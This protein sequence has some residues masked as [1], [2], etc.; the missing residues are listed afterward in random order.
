M[1]SFEMLPLMDA[2]VQNPYAAKIEEIFAAM[3]M[4]QSGRINLVLADSEIPHGVQAGL[5]ALEIL[6]RRYPD[7]QAGWTEVY[8]ALSVEEYFLAKSL[9]K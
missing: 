9:F 4:D 7:E 2:P 3:M 5:K 1:G 6:A 8:Q